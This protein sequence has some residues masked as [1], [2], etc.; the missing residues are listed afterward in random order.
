[1]VVPDRPGPPPRPAGRA[2]R[3]GWDCSSWLPARCP[4]SRERRRRAASR[5]QPPA[6]AAVVARYDLL[7]TLLRRGVGPGHS[8]GAGSRA[9]LNGECVHED[10]ELL[11]GPALED[12]VAVR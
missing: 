7:F 11:D 4:R 2:R 5:T 10:L 8:D 12:A 1:M 3:P 9:A 6:A